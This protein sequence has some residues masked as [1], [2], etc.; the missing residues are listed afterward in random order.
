VIV[1]RPGLR[2]T[3][4]RP[5]LRGPVVITG[6]DTG[7]G[8][9]ITTA[10]IA[11]TATNAGLRVAVLKPGQTGIPDGSSEQSDV[12]IV[13]QL[14]GPRTAVT[15]ATYPDPLAPSAAARVSGRPPLELFAVVNRA[16]ELGAEHDLVLI[17]G[18]GGLLVP[19]GCTSAAHAAQGRGAE[20]NVSDLATV[21]SAPAV[22]VVR[23]GLGT[24]NHTALTLEALAR[25]QVTAH[26]V[27]GSWP[28]EPE[29]VHRTNLDD[30]AVILRGR[31]EDGRSRVLAG[32]RPHDEF[33]PGPR[34]HDEFLAGPRPHD[35]FLDGRLPEGAGGL[36]PAVF[37]AQ[38]VRWLSPTLYGEF[39][40]TPTA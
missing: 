8:K 3:V 22:V 35:E 31:P 10:A 11:A 5:G 18:A 13:I 34:P 33:L 1:D 12:E 15:M 14:A 28:A 21:L 7:V 16:R 20:W 36:P 17:E 6:T 37:R 30:L 29:L 40:S 9:T 19:M 2:V 27:I 38:A 26:V 4:D 39:S 25:R 23:A 32:P 24:L